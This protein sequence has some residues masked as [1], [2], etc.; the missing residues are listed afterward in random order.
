[1]A[2]PR[3]TGAVAKYPA[4]SALGA[5]TALIVIG[6]LLLRL[7]MCHADAAR[8]LSLLDAAF[9]STS[10]V[11]VTGLSVRSVGHDLSFL[12]QAVLLGLIQLGGIGIITVTTLVSLG[13]RKSANVRQNLAVAEALGSRATDDPRWVVRMVVTAVLAIE[14]LGFVLLFARNLTEFAPADAAWHALFHSVSAFCNAGFGLFDDNL[15]RYR[16][17]ILVNLTIC[18]LIILGGIG[19]PV[20]LDVVRGVRDRRSNWFE[21]LSLHTKLVLWGTA[22][23]LLAGT[24]AFLA[25]EQENTL[26]GLPW[27]EQLLAAFFHSTT[28]RTAGF[29]TVD[30]ARLTDAMLFMSIL[31]M[32][33]GAAPC[34][35]G[36]GFKV[37]TL[38]V[39]GLVARD[40]LRGYESVR[41]AKRTISEGLIDRSLAVVL[42]FLLVA[43]AGLTAML[44]VELESVPHLKSGGLFIESMFEVVS[45]LCTVGLST[46]LTT[47]LGEGGR[48]LLILLML[49]GRLGPF[50]LFVAVSRVRRDLRLEYA[51]ED[52]LIG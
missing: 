22:G 46:G 32:L 13:D 26:A 49:I 23:L 34:S 21:D 7:P 25:L 51:K 30:I 35:A 50:S 14:G 41:F 19:F 27:H 11:C 43:G 44:G 31:L 37:S 42:L 28:C 47:Q 24:V 6:A 9:M 38:M 8:P 12:G 18:G 29:N 10:A 16:S 20:M 4:R 15:V 52:V 33:V 48:G 3:F 2:G 1:M 5:Y 40:K 17:D 39:L 36:G 45:A